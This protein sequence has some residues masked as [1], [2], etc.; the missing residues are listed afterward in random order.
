MD[1]I[2]AVPNPRFRGRIVPLLDELV[3][4]SSDDELFEGLK[5]GRTAYLWGDS[6]DPNSRMLTAPRRA[7]YGRDGMRDQ[8]VSLMALGEHLREH[9]NGMPLGWRWGLDIEFRGIWSTK[10]VPLTGSVSNSVNVGRR[11]GGVSG[12]YPVFRN[13]VD[14]VAAVVER[15]NDDSKRPSGGL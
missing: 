4:I 5:R 2:S 1:R 15:S 3:L 6:I 14:T 13:W 8:G 10:S 9:G 11:D 12:S 7:F